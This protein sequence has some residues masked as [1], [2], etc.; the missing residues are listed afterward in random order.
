MAPKVTRDGQLAREARTARRGAEP[1]EKI[2]CDW[3]AYGVCVRMES[4]IKWSGVDVGTVISSVR[5]TARNKTD[6]T[7]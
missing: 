1:P 7:C 2:A 5:N 6:G 3:V 4:N